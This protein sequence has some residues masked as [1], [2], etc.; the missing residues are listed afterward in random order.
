M[1]KGKFIE[2][3]DDM[4]L[5]NSELFQNYYNDVAS[6]NIS[7][8]NQI[9]ENNDQLQNQITDS[10]NVN[11]LIERVNSNEQQIKTDVDEYL[12]D[13]LNAFQDLINQTK[14]AGEFN[15]A[16]QYKLHN[17]VYYQDK[18]YYAYKTPP[19]GTLPTD[20]NYWL[21]YD[22]RGLKGYGGINLNYRFT[23]D[24]DI[25]YQVMDCVVY[26]NK[27][28]FANQPNKGAPPTLAHYPWLPI[29]MP[30][31]PV[32]AQI[33]TTQPTIAMSTG[34]FWFK[35]TKGD[36]IKQ[37]KWTDKAKQTYFRYA[38]AV[39]T[40]GNEIH[41]C[42]GDNSLDEKQTEH[43]VYN[44]LTNTWSEKVALPVGISGMASF[45]IGD[46]GYSVGGINASLVAIPTTY[47]YD[48]TSN[49]WSTGRDLPIALV[50]LMSGCSGVGKNLF[51]ET[52]YSDDTLYSTG[53]GGMGAY[54]AYVKLPDS[55]K[56]KFY[57]N[58]FLKGAIQN[59]LAI[60]FST[61]TSDVT[62]R[63]YD[64]GVYFE[65]KECD[66]TNAENVYFV[67]GNSN[68]VTIDTDVKTIFDNFNIMVTKEED[69]I[70]EPH[71]IGYF[72][73]SQTAN[74]LP[75]NVTFSYN[76]SANTWKQL[77]DCPNYLMG[78]NAS[79]CNGKIYVMGGVNYTGSAGD[80]LY[81]YDIATN[82][83][84][85]GAPEGINRSF[86]SAFV[87]GNKIYR[88]GGLNALGY[89]MSNVMIYDTETNTWAKEVTME[90]KRTSAQATA[91]NGKGYVIGGININNDFGVFGYNEEYNPE[92]ERRYK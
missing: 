69:N 53:T 63:V 45:T 92:A 24:A 52:K 83:W 90:H 30:L 28:W 27:L 19:I 55:F 77:A 79:Y 18:G 68:R 88:C 54:F 39:F 13:Q 22:I 67:I 44:T 42:G 87:I 76:P 15:A 1:P 10:D 73:T 91:V 29:M 40:F 59:N 36:D 85:Q 23:W 25:Q 60:G 6:R 62:Y 37:T 46:K 71:E 43:Q 80:F 32:K 74:N 50:P 78:A 48:N 9:I 41:I 7:G 66:F 5:S 4:H 8:A 33:S 84:S 65:N 38:S 70:Y 11:K 75:S 57:A 72:A 21:E 61:N 14:V 17:L 89:S 51:D 56:T 47:I 16:T 34:D 58:V 64:K 86:A 12:Q 49:T 31:E 35:I 82:T 26:Q 81:I 20:T 3:M 2:L